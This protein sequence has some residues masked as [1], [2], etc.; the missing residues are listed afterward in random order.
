MLVSGACRILYGRGGGKMVV[1]EFQGGKP[2]SSTMEHYSKG[3]P[4]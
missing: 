3:A 2:I 4:P 1:E